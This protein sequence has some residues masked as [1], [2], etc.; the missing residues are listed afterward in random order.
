MSV[1]GHRSAFVQDRLD[2]E[3]TPENKAKIEANFDRVYKLLRG[4]GGV[5]VGMGTAGNTGGTSGYAEGRLVLV[6]SGGLSLSQS[7]SLD[8][9][10]LTLNVNPGIIISA[11]TLTG[12]RSSVIFSNSNG[13]SFGMSGSTITAAGGG[14]AV[15][16]ST[17]GNTTG[18]TKMNVGGSV[19][20][21]GGNNI[22]LSQSTDVNGATLT[23]SAF[24]QSVQSQGFT[25]GF[26]DNMPGIIMVTTNESQS[27]LKIGPLIPS[28][29]PFPGDMTV[30]TIMLLL[31]NNLN[32]S[33]KGI[34]RSYWFAIYTPSNTSQ[35][36]LMYMAS[37]VFTAQAFSSSASG[38][39][40]SRTRDPEQAAQGIRFL[41]I[42][43]SRVSDAGG[44]AV[45][46]VLRAGSHYWW[47][48]LTIS[49]TNGQSYNIAAMMGISGIGGA[50]VT[51][52]LG[53]T[54]GVYTIGGD[55]VDKRLWTPFYGSYSANVATLPTTI[56]MTDI[57]GN[58]Q[59]GQFLQRIIFNVSQAA[60]WPTEV[61]SGTGLNLSGVSFV[62][63]TS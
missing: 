9:A 4:V 31:S 55:P 49:D 19:V 23:I 46:F 57:R 18:T 42:H 13:I 43:N 1:T 59:F 39:T 63:N 25:M 52:G 14:P 6:G 30:S 33:T 10:T 26:F 7:F 8:S 2:A 38:A 20:L 60:Q 47:G 35:L 62:V 15:G 51:A 40:T 54:I 53:G 32:V 37:T 45:P 11:G 17:I 36:S 21:A 22:T 61:S 5:A 41:T 44:N 16:M 24:T 28:M 27:A 56:A 58:L 3:W 50:N 12:V 34:T 29:A 48:G